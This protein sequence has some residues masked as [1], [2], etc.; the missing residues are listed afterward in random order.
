MLRYLISPVK[1]F[2]VVTAVGVG[3]K[4][5]RLHLLKRF[6][7]WGTFFE[8]IER[9]N[10]CCCCCWV[11]SGICSVCTILLWRQLQETVEGRGVGEEH[12]SKEVLVELKRKLKVTVQ[13]TSRSACVAL[14]G[15]RARAQLRTS[16]GSGQAAAA[17]AAAA[18]RS[19]K[20]VA[21]F[22]FES[23]RAFET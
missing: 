15:A 2:L 5:I 12:G 20:K 4:G 8:L 6:K 7:S 10:D 9:G 14:A 13:F 22:C 1:M 3:D 11:Q 17:A 18:V 21:I 16:S 19:N 23:S